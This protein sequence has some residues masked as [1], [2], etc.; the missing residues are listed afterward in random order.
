MADLR[1]GN[2]LGGVGNPVKSAGGAMPEGG[3]GFG[4]LIRDALKSTADASHKAEQ[5]SGMAAMGKADV[6]DIVTAV[7]NAEVALDTVVS[8]R[9]KV[10]NAYQE[11]MR[12]PI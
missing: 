7:T 9:D 6:T 11:I 1:I 10:I 12:M 4:E 2:F 3:G 5:I 8:V